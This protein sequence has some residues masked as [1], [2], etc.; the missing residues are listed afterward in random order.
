M[1]FE[2]TSTEVAI[3]DVNEIIDYIA[4]RNPKAAGRLHAGILSRIESLQQNPHVGSILKRIGSKVI[5][6][7]NYRSY[8]IL[9][10][11]DEAAGQVD[12]LSVR[13]GRRKSSELPE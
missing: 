4:Q 7:W 6:E 8:R 1:P 10:S 11:V 2:V 5:R 9:L 13:H 12:V 3:S